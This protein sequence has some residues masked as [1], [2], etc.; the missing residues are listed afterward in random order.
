[1]TDVEASDGLE[2][3]AP[4]SWA[5]PVYEVFNPDYSVG[6]ACDRSGAIVGLH[7]GDEVWENTD[8]WL[9][10][11]ILRVAKL[12]YMKSRVG[13]RAELLRNGGSSRLADEM[14]LPTEAAYTIAEKTEFGQP[15]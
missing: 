6:V 7:L 13:R 8:A 1:M 11:E 2:A 14:G 5:N 3:N 15:L 10:A 12:A 9:A 4:P